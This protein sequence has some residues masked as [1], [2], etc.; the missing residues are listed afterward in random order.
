M[1]DLILHPTTLESPPAVSEGSA[2]LLPT[3]YTAG[4]NET[5]Y[6]ANC[7]VEATEQFL[8]SRKSENTRRAYAHQ[9]KAFLAWANKQPWQITPADLQ[10]YVAHCRTHSDKDETVNARI[11][12]ISSYY[13]YLQNDYHINLPGGQVGALIAYNPAAAKSLRAKINAYGKSAY[14]GDAEARALLKA[15]DRKTLTGLRDYALLL[16]YLATGRRSNEI[17]QLRFGDFTEVDGRMFYRW[18]G[19]GKKDKKN[20]IPLRVWKSIIAYLKASGRP[21]PQPE[22]HL[23]VSHSDHAARLPNVPATWQPGVSPLSARMVGLIL[24]RHA[25]RAGLKAEHVHPHT[26]RHTA[27]MLRKKAGDD[28]EKICAF[29]GH[30]SIAV[31]QV[32]L[33]ELEGQIDTSWSTVEAL[34][35]L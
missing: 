26:L 34:L 33:H 10:N 15:I 28:V 2:V 20:E 19:K 22:D 5:D 8:A 14:L 7:W 13:R 30:S 35:G 11:A 3:G 24:K 16:T 31:T 6:L 18:S 4:Y 12:A 17:R 21:N 25:R 23:F 9:L 27:A 29:L 1:T 32:Y